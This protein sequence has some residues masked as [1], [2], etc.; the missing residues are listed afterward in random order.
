MPGYAPENGLPF[1]PQAARRLLSAAGHPSGGDLP[2]VFCVVR[3]ARRRPLQEVQAQWRRHLNIEVKLRLVPPPDFMEYITKEQPP[4]FAAG[5]WADYND[6]DNFLRICVEMDLPQWRHERYW[7]L[8]AQA[9]RTTVQEERLALYQQVDALFMQEAVLIP[10]IY[11][12]QHVMLKP[13]VRRF[14]TAPVK[15]SGFW[16]DVLIRR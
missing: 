1:Q 14:P 7:A 8:L 5:W 15:H 16:K 4:I 13:W 10:L 9:R 6:P 12:E 3:P 11:S 2:P